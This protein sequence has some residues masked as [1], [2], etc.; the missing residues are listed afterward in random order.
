MFNFKPLIGKPISAVDG[1]STGPVIVQKITTLDPIIWND[2]ASYQQGLPVIRD[3]PGSFQG[4]EQMFLRLHSPARQPRVRGWVATI[5]EVFN[6]HSLAW[7]TFSQVFRQTE[8][9]PAGGAGRGRG[10]RFPYHAVELRALVP[11]RPSPSTFGFAS[12][13][14][15]EIFSSLGNDF[16]EELHF[17]TAERLAW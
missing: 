10:I 16:R 7:S 6:L 17:D 1:R 5:H 15:S 3:W 9:N 8:L 4:P 14:L 11:E 13:E 2:Q 12:T